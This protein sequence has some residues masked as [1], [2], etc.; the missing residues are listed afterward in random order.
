MTRAGMIRTDQKPP[1]PLFKG[2]VRLDEGRE[3]RLLA[4]TMIMADFSLLLQR[5]QQAKIKC[6]P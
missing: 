5:S 3:D 4:G 2:E 1:G 6:S